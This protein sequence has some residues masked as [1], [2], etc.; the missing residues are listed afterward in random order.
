M[1]SKEY[2]IQYAEWLSGPKSVVGYPETPFV[3]HPE[4]HHAQ[5][6]RAQE[7]QTQQVGSTGKRRQGH[8]A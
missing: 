2:Q 7:G 8:A 3:F 4:I 1:A 5:G 6:R